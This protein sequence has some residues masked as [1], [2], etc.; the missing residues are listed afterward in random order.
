M[1]FFD[2]LVYLGNVSVLLSHRALAAVP[3]HTVHIILWWLCRD[4][5]R[6]V[7]KYM[8]RGF[9]QL[10]LDDPSFSTQRLQRLTEM[11]DLE[12]AH[13]SKKYLRMDAVRP[14]Q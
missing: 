10:L 12:F 1:Q 5:P 9:T 2:E 8:E 7:A 3:T 11:M 13:E 4:E 6:R 14:L